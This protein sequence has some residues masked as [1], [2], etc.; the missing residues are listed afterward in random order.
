[1]DNDGFNPR[2][3]I[4]TWIITFFIAAAAGWGVSKIEPQ[5]WLLGVRVF[6]A[7][8]SGLLVLA[9]EWGVIFIY[10]LLKDIG[11]ADRSAGT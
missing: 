7:V 1:M 11:E 8:V 5:A 9:A 2:T 10:S 6:L 4:P 3:A